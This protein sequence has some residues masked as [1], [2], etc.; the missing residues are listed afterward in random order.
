MCVVGIQ[1]TSVYD[2]IPRI[3]QKFVSRT[4]PGHILIKPYLH[5]F[6]LT[7]ISICLL[8]HMS[9]ETQQHILISGQGEKFST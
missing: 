3:L 9:K 7:Q 1:E 4:R 8:C 6:K 2:N 5:R